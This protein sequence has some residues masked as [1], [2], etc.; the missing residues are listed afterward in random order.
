MGGA[1]LNGGNT[2]WFDSYA[3]GYF[4][5]GADTTVYWSAA[6]ER[7]FGDTGVTA[8]LTV[9]HD[10]SPDWYGLAGISGGSA[11]FQNRRRLD[12]TLFHKWPDSRRWITGIGLM[13]AASGDG[14]HRDFALRGS[15]IYYSDQAW[16]AEG[17][18]IVNRSNPGSVWGAR[19]YGAITLGTEK[20]HYLSL[21]LEHGKEAYL[22]VQV[23]G[24]PGNVEFNSTELTLQWR[25]WINQRWGYVVGAQAYRNP[26][27]RRLGVSVGL[28]MDF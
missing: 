8:G 27:Y 7:H 11:P 25:Q 18:V 24:Y 9:V 12:L 26:Y 17:G 10:F 28:F 4:K 3:R 14:I 21:R 15:V 5:P 20:Q 23:P 1:D 2:N 16:V 6:N 22:P 19:G 13:S